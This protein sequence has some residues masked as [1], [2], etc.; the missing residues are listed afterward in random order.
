MLIG[1]I[2]NIEIEK[3]QICRYQVGFPFEKKG[4]VCQKHRLKIYSFL[5]KETDKKIRLSYNGEL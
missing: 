3:V 1:Y 5:L 4:L 2:D